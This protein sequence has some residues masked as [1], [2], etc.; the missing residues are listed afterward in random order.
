LNEFL[1]TIAI[2]KSSD[3]R[4]SFPFLVERV[5]DRHGFWTG[6]F[7]SL[8]VAGAHKF[9]GGFEIELGWCGFTVSARYKIA[10]VLQDACGCEPV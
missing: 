4:F 3:D 6:L 1:N 5:R 2:R 8:K 9:A 7:R 10:L